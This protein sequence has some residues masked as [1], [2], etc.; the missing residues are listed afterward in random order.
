MSDPR[1]PIG[2][3]HDSGDRSSERRATLIRDLQNLPA[4]L[5]AAVSGMSDSQLDTPYRD[6]GWT[7]RQVIHHLGDAN[8]NAYLRMKFAVADDRPTI[9]PYDEDVWA[10]FADAKGPVEPT[11]ALLQ[12]LHL[13]WSLF[14]RSLDE[15]QWDRVFIHPQNGETPVAKS[16]ELYVWHGRHHLAHVTELKKLKGW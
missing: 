5:R 6:G 9:L 4:D 15:A 2:R 7:V 13:R 12:A 11:L 14:L 8:V 3:F 1:Y 10:E 16:L